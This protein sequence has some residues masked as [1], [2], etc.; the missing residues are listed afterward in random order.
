MLIKADIDNVV[1]QLTKVLDT[2]CSCEFRRSKKK[3]EKL[4]E[5]LDRRWD[6][7]ISLNCIE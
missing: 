3:L 4:K 2:Q 1:D 5:I 7:P 6:E